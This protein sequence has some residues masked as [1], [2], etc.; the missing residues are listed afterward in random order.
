M[1]HQPGAGVT[2]LSHDEALVFL[3]KFATALNVPFS[4]ERAESVMEL[5]GGSFWFAEPGIERR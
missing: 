4:R 2:C 3:Q 1:L 5:C